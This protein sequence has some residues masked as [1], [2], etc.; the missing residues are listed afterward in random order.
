ML[1][2]DSTVYKGN[3]FTAGF[4][5]AGGA[6]DSKNSVEQVS[7]T[8]PAA[9]SYTFRVKA[10]NAPGSRRINTKRQ[11]YALAVSGAFGLP[12]QAA[13]AAPTAVS[14]IGNDAVNGVSI[15]FTIAS[16][17]QSIQLYRA[18]G[19]CATAV[20]GDFRLVG[21]AATNPIADKVCKAVSATPSSYVRYRTML[22]VMLRHASMWFR[23]NTCSLQPQFD[24]SG[25]SANSISSTCQVNFNWNAANATCPTSTGITYNVLRDNNPYFTSAATLISGLAAALIHGYGSDVWRYPV[26]R[27]P[28][29]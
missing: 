18:N 4:S 14:V 15:N 13:L 27:H 6:A 22:K 24:E 8:A 19:T 26:L 20:P 17:A 3:V 21:A 12:D 2:P 5:V 25:I 9:G 28:G 16:G 7:F 10:T 23:K 11:G 29:Q 1:G